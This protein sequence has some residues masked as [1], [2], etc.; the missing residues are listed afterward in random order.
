MDH[1]LG[2][3]CKAGRS[4][5]W[6]RGSRRPGAAAV[7]GVE[8]RALYRSNPQEWGTLRPDGRD[9]PDWTQEEV[10][11]VPGCTDAALVP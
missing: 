9:A 2:R 4:C 8:K 1:C 3:L 5:G 10:T 11:A 6:M 7:A